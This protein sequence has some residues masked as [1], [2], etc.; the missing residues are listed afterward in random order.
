MPTTPPPCTPSAAA[1]K[2]ALV[3]DAS[4]GAL[5]Q[6]FSYHTGPVLD[7]D[8]APIPLG[9]GA[10]ASA[11]PM[12]FASASSDRSVA[13]CTLGE[14]GAA[15]TRHFTGHTDEVNAV[16]WAPLSA[17]AAGRPSSYL[18]ASGS[19]DGTARLWSHAVDAYGGSGSSSGGGSLAVLAGHR[20]AVYSLEW[21]PA[22]AVAAGAPLLLAT[23]SFDGS[24]RLWDTAGGGGACTATLTPR[25]TA[26][27]APGAVYSVAWSPDGALLASGAADRAVHIWSASDGALLRSYIAP[28]GVF[29]VAWGGAG[30]TLVAAC[31]NGAVAVLHLRR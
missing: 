23:A 8:W 11:A 19:D 26:G 12:M 5:S 13:V 14:R 16:S 18:L 31:A 20:K 28:A 30:D 25:A 1:D 24:V 10:S 2:T 27:S 7:V 17:T 6:S 29:E 3:W 21:A 22:A 9:A 15:P 4:T